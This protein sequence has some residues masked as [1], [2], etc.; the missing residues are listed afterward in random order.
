MEE[1]IGSDGLFSDGDWV[2]SKD[3]DPEGKIRLL[4]LA[5][6]GGSTFLNK[7]ARFVNDE[8]YERLRCTEV[9]E[10]DIL[11]ARMPDPLGRAC[12]VPSLNQRLIT[13][14]DIA[15]VRTG[16]EAAFPQWLM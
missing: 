13:V 8:Q 12:L 9:L 5:D 10:G 3:Q 15:I 14:V 11:I 4:Q 1:L 2:E 7:S 6:I 16:S